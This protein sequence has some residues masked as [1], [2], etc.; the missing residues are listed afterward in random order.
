MRRDDDYQAMKDRHATR[1]P[2]LRRPSFRLSLRCLCGS[3]LA[4]TISAPLTDVFKLR[5][6]FMAHH[7][8]PGCDV[9]DTSE[10]LP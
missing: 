10:D 7:R 8:E 3:T 6:I 9:E 4:G 1:R 5:D 2:V